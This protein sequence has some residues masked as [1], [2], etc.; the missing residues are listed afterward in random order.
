M[1]SVFIP[2]PFAPHLAAL[3]ASDDIRRIADETARRASSLA[4]KLTG[5]LAASVSV[6]PAGEPGGWTVAFDVPY[7]PFVEFGTY[8]DAAQPFLRPAAGAV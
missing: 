8:K 1:A 2:N 7:A 5:A 4:P 3:Q 6:V